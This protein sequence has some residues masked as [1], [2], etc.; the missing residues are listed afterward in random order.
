[1]ARLNQNPVKAVLAGTEGWAAVD[2][3][4]GDDVGLTPL[5]ITQFAQSNMALASGIDQGLMSGAQATKL[6]AL[7]AVAS[8]N[9][10]IGQLAEVA[11]PIFVSSPAD[12]TIEIY[13]HV[14]D[15][16]WV[17]DFARIG[18]S[19]GSTNV[20]LMKNGA[21]IAGLTNCPISVTAAT[22]T[23]TDTVPNMTLNSGDVLGITLAG[24]TGT[25]KNLML[26]LRANSVITP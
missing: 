18:L 13:T 22:F 8:L 20:T 10:Q 7:P 1:M 24:T 19:A 4:T 12:G 5:T 15:T 23:G 6:N 17:L 25:A 11:F 21:N 2:P 3:S 14:L 16:P 9:S 26:S